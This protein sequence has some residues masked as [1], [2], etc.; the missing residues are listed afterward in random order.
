LLF[1][2]YFKISTSSHCDL[3]SRILIPVIIFL[4]IRLKFCQTF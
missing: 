3:S 1:L 4:Y 2:S